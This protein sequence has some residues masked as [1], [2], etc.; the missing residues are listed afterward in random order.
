[1][2]VGDRNW[3]LFTKETVASENFQV[4]PYNL[5]PKAPKTPPSSPN[6][7]IIPL[8]PLPPQQGVGGGGSHPHYFPPIEQTT[9]RNQH[10][11]TGNHQHEKSKKN[12]DFT[13]L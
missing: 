1:M 5:S 4:F 10:T 8:Y 7:I 2:R 12:L 11:L 13:I 9:H 3:Y 6:G